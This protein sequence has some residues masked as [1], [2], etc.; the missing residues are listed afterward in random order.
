[1]KITTTDRQ[2]LKWKR[3][4]LIKPNFHAG[5]TDTHF[6]RFDV[7]PL[8][9]SSIASYLDDLDVDVEIFDAKIKNLSYKKIRSE[10][11]KFDPDIVGISVFIS[12]AIYTSYDI[13]KMVK[14]INPNCTVVFGNHHPTHFPKETLEV[15]EVDIVVR[16][17]GELTFRELII[18]GSPENVKGI[19]YRSNG[20]IIH[21]P[22]RDFM[23]DIGTL[24]YPARNLIKNNK[25]RTLSITLETIEA[26]RG[27][28][29]NCKFC[30]TPG[31]YK[32][33]WRPRPVEKIIT[34]LKLISRNRK[35]TDIL[36]VDDNFTADTKRIEKLCERII[37]CKKNKEI[38]DFKFFAEARVDSVAKAPQMVKKMADAGF[39]ILCVGIESTSAEILKEMKKSLTFN[40]TLRA[41][42]IMHENNIFIIGNLIIGYNLNATEEEIKKEMDFI[43]KLK[44]DL[45]D[46]KILTPYPGTEIRKE[47]EE[48][49]LILSNDWS[50]YIFITPVIRTHTLTPKKLHELLRYSYREIFDLYNWKETLSRIRKSRGLRFLLNPK[51]II[52]WAKN[53]FVIRTIKRVFFND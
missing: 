53:F 30:T 32:S 50:K 38:N 9:L 49:N 4:L 16:G 3:I 44:I 27:C 11:K 6:A 18:K 20:I 10:I 23:K 7:P 8:G 5:N 22:D 40:K 35:I 29:Y 47:L 19:S 39:W 12:A 36:F 45:V 34:E 37:E 51:R 31:F 17:E 21:N 1:M 13:A 25:Y 28:P 26:S 24:R 42:K 14:E 52:F 41:L 48:K 33:T 46:Y 2:T 15:D 43:K